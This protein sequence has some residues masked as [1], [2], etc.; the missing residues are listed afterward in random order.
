MKLHELLKTKITLNEGINFS[1][2]Q[3]RIFE[4]VLKKLKELNPTMHTSYA[5]ELART[6]DQFFTPAFDDCIKAFNTAEDISEIESELE[7]TIAK[8]S[9]VIIDYFSN[10]DNHPAGYESRKLVSINRDIPTREEIASLI[11]KIY[12]GLDKE[13]ENRQ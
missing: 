8:V 10:S 12:P 1:H 3:Q 2:L 11:K 7:E 9:E 6:T 4:Y 5:L 13:L